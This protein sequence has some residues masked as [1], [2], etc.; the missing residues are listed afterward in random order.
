MENYEPHLS[1]Q[2]TVVETKQPP[3]PPRSVLHRMQSVRRFIHT[4]LSV[5]APLLNELTEEEDVDG[6]SEEDVDR[7]AEV[8]SI[9][10][11]FLT[12][13]HTEVPEEEE[14]SEED[15]WDNKYLVRVDNRFQSH[16]RRMFGVKKIDC[17]SNE[18]T[19]K[20]PKGVVPLSKIFE[21]MET[22]KRDSRLHIINYT[23][24]Q[25]NLEQVYN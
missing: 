9:E 13:E 19:Y 12:Q 10:N 24:S 23:I 7:L 5:T 8:E 4:Q 16:F 14:L 1:S 11:I 2:T 3:E 21:V 6:L 20:L 22:M 18:I 17:K 25:S 15:Y